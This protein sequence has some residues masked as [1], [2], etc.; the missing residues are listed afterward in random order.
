MLPYSLPLM[1]LTFCILF[2]VGRINMLPTRTAAHGFSPFEL[3]TGRSISYSRDLGARRGGKPLAF[4]S[5]CEVYTTTNNT[6][7]DRTRTALWLGPSGNSFGSGIFFTLDTL[8]IVKR[9]QWKGLPM[10]QGTINRVERISKNRGSVPKKLQEGCDYPDEAS[11]Q[12]DSSNSTMPVTEGEL[13]DFTLP[14]EEPQDMYVQHL[15]RAADILPG[16]M[17]DQF[18]AAH[19]DAEPEDTEPTHDSATPTMT[20]VEVEG[21]TELLDDQDEQKYHHPASTNEASTIDQPWFLHGAPLTGNEGR[22]SR[23]R[24]P[25]QRLTYRA[26]SYTRSLSWWKHP[27]VS[28]RQSLIA[29]GQQDGLGPT[30]P[31]SRVIEVDE[32]LPTTSV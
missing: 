8:T 18:P 24:V 17:I 20:S 31:L 30:C 16:D 5:R 22:G 3:F 12:Q 27:F 1:L 32:R 29:I 23:V 19:D 4:G 2:C 11:Q 15:V 28:Q 14:G 6:M 26:S 25:P 10:D 9:D 21:R 7:N 13:N